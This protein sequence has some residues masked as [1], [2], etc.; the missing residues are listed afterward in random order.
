MRE[1]RQS[2]SEG[3][4]AFGSLLP[5]SPGYG[6]PHLCGSEEFFVRPRGGTD[7]LFAGVHD[8]KVGVRRLSG[9]CQHIIFC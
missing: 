4:V 6:T 3:G 1:T 2:G 5:L 7:S 8:K 9:E